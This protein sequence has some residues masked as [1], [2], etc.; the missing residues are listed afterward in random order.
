M[1]K[2][3]V[4]DDQEIIQQVIRDMLEKTGHEVLVA[5]HGQEALDILEEHSVDIVTVDL[6]MP[7]M[8]GIELIRLQ[9]KAFP[10][11]KAMIVSGAKDVLSCLPP[12]FDGVPLVRKPFSTDDIQDAVGS[13]LQ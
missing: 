8:N 6:L 5:G 4:V 2:I 7:G 3:L 13:L 10:N 11:V 1:A 12:E 9:R